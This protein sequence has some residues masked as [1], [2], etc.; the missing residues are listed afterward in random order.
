MGF[1]LAASQLS[2]GWRWRRCWSWREHWR[3]RRRRRQID[4]LWGTWGLIW[5]V[6]TSPTTSTPAPTVATAALVGSMTV[7]FT[8]T[9]SKQFGC[10]LGARLATNSFASVLIRVDQVQ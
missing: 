5:I 3:W 8:L 2:R 7:G 1:T 4:T 10:V 9:A 6:P